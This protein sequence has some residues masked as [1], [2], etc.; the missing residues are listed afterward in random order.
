MTSVPVDP[1][2]SGDHDR[3]DQVCRAVPFVVQRP[4]NHFENSGRYP[5]IS[6][7]SSRAR[8]SSD[9]DLTSQF[10]SKGGI[11]GHLSEKHYSR[12]FYTEWHG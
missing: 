5:G 11:V 10:L 1:P 2:H 8:S 7:V 4:R 9:C 6:A 3:L 12:L